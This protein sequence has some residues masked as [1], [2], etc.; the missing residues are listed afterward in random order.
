LILADTVV[1]N[2]TFSIT[3]TEAF[4]LNNTA[5]TNTAGTT[6]DETTYRIGSAASSTGVALGATDIVTI[7]ISDL[8]NAT[9]TGLKTTLTGR[10]IDVNMAATVNYVVDGAAATAAQIALVAKAD[11]ARADVT[12]AAAAG[13]AAPVAGQAFTSTSAAIATA[14]ITG[15]AG[16]DT[17]TIT[18]AG[19]AVAIAF[20]ATVTLIENL[21]LANGT[22]NFTFNAANAFTSI[23]GGTGTDT[24]NLAG[25]G[26]GTSVNAGAGIDNVTFGGA[27]T[28][29]LDG[30]LGA[31]T[32]TMSANST[33]NGATITSFE[34]L[35]GAFTASMTVAQM[36]G[37]TTAINTGAGAGGTV[38]LTDAG[39]AAVTGTTTH[40]VLANGTND[41]TAN[42]A[43]SHNITGGTGADTITL[44]SLDAADTINGGLGIDTLVITNNTGGFIANQLSNL[45]VITFTGPVGGPTTLTLTSDVTA[46]TGL[47][48]LTVNAT[49]GASQVVVTYGGAST[50][51]ATINGSTGNDT[52]TGG[53][54]ADTINGGA[55]NDSIVASAGTDRIT[56]G[57][58]NDIFVLMA[59]A[60]TAVAGVDVITDFTS[61]A[62]ASNDVIVLNL[63]NAG[64]IN[65]KANLAALAAGD[66][67]DM[68]IMTDALSTA[69]ITAV[70]GNAA[71][72]AA[73]AVFNSSTGRGEIWFD[74][75]WSD[76]AGRTQLAT[77]D[78]LTTLIQITGLSAVDGVDFT[79][80]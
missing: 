33:F 14:T 37:F 65:T 77:L 44:A 1:G 15:A 13:A 64:I 16:T 72:N 69:Q 49:G 7:D 56:L 55:G 29:T 53:A 18:D 59:V 78:N 3:L 67:G 70:G 36:N 62:V 51:G 43:V 5:G 46:T 38:T 76:T 4:L 34:T 39:I 19:G 22:N 52:L 71:A 10:G 12:G 2:S 9:R 8:L 11:A 21:M 74:T 31:D 28:G 20:P 80:L 60:N 50:V 58:G 25:L 73:I 32:F 6:I 63:D 42:S 66:A 61:G 79:I 48:S 23:T 54:Q 40:F 24:L 30:G 75:D 41:F 17:L 27:L 26:L 68:V 35:A 57:E 45:E 47:G